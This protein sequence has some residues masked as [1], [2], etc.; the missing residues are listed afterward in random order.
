M[1]RTTLLVALAPFLFGA[2]SLLFT[3]GPPVGH[4][5]MTHFECTQS[6]TAPVVDI[7]V[8]ALNLIGAITIA[9]NRADYDNPDQAITSG[10]V[11]TV[12]S[13]ISAGVGF[14]RVKRCVAAKRALAQRQ[15]PAPGVTVEAPLGNPGV[16]AV[17]IT[18]GKDTLA[19][20]ERMQLVAKAFDSNRAVILGKTFAWSSSN[21]AIASVSNAGLVTTHATGTVVIAANSDNVV[22]TARVVVVSAP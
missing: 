21:D 8:G 9:G 7:A 19:V 15:A 17:L 22:G 16:Q 10:F 2:C 11:W 4:E 3:K 1:R 18:S 14:D 13:G 12:I 5:T 20:G 6:T